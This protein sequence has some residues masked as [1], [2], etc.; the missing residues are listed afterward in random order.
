MYNRLIRQKRAETEPMGKWEVRL[1]TSDD[2]IIIGER[3]TEQEAIALV[4]EHRAGGND[5]KPELGDLVV[6]PSGFMY[7]R[8]WL[9]SDKHMGLGEYMIYDKAEFEKLPRSDE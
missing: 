8:I 6:F 4:N 5:V 2:Q 3:D 7:R 9:N 1:V